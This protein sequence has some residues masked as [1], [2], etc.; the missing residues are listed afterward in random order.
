MLGT[1]LRARIVQH[2]IDESEQVALALLHAGEGLCLLG[3]YGSV[4]TQLDEL[5]VPADRIQRG[6]QLVAH[7]REKLALGAIGVL[8]SL[9]RLFG[10]TLRLLCGR[11]RRLGLHVPVLER[12]G[13]FAQFARAKLQLMRLLL[14]QRIGPFQRLPRSHRL[15]YVGAVRDDGGVGAVGLQQR[16]VR[17]IH[18]SLLEG[19]GRARQ[20]D[21]EIAKHEGFPSVT[22]LLGCFVESLAPG[23]R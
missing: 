16:E 13:G 6:A 22:N 18:I 20:K 5:R 12:E 9:P 11:A 10:I 1:R 3:C 4:H 14:K 2:A 17:D 19:T 23:F 15:G 8:R 21:G 7:D